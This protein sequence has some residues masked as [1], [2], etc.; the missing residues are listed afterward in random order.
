[1]SSSACCFFRL[2]HDIEILIF[3]PFYHSFFTY[4]IKI[5]SITY[6]AY[7]S[8]IFDRHLACSSLE[9]LWIMLS[10]FQV[11]VRSIFMPGHL[12]SRCIIH[13]ALFYWFQKWLYHFASLK[14]WVRAPLTLYIYQYLVFFFK[15]PL[16]FSECA[17]EFI[18]L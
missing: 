14:Q 13:H 15:K 16:Y 3:A 6:L 10:Y 2:I 17:M 8:I 5:Y 7:L 12:V 4:F 11:C 1:M 9:L 18:L